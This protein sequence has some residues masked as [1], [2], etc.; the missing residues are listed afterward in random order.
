M[1]VESS[2]LERYSQGAKN[3]QASLCCAVEYD[4]NLLHILPDEI[5]EKDYGCGDPSRFVQEGD[6]VLDLGS[7]SGKICYMAAQIVGE[8]GRVIGIDMNDDMLELARRY[9]PEMD[10]KL[11]GDRVSFLKGYIQNLAV[12]LEASDRY[13]AE[14]PISNST[15]LQ[16]YRSWQAEQCQN[17]PLIKDNSVDLVVS[18]CVLNLVSDSDKQQ[19]LRE[20]FRV[21]KPG[22]R[23]AISDIVSDE[24]VP[25]HLK[26]DPEL[27]SGCISGA[28]QE[29]DF[30]QSFVEVGFQAVELEKWEVEPWQTVDMLEFRSVTIT[31]TKPKST[32]CLDKGHAVIYRGPFSEVYNDDGHFFPR[33][34]R[35]AVCERT[36]ELL[37]KGP[38]K[39][40][41]IGIVPAELG[42]GIDVCMPPGKRRPARETKG[43]VH[44]GQQ[45][46]SS[47]CS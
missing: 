23:V 43:A 18:N 33:G 10:K 22:G 36:F 6:V 25:D 39:D 28:L 29:T 4:N 5:I 31:A 35:I 12:D 3:A 24:V 26:A 1:S 42:A 46:S 7:G 13:L 2:V 32:Q 44:I 19:L 27:W 38:Y 17:S 45:V 21:T 11:G 9:K 20:I 30:M 41:F 15:D 47:C 16:N 34:E 40:A 14:S 8:K 37:T